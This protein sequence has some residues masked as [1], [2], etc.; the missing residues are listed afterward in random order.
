M[1]RG[2]NLALQFLHVEGDRNES[3]DVDHIPMIGKTEPLPVD[4]SLFHGAA[5]CFR[6]RRRRALP[7]KSKKYRSRVV[8]ETTD[9]A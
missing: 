1:H 3:R 9:S 2:L 5:G 7:T 8:S 4:N 6:R